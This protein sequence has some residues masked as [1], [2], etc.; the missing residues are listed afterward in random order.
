MRGRSKRLRWMGRGGR[1]GR[2][3]RLMALMSAVSVSL[4]PAMLTAQEG[5]PAAG[6]PVPTLEGERVP[7]GQTI[8]HGLAFL[9]AEAAV[10]RVREIEPPGPG[11]A[12]AE[13]GDFAFTLQIDGVTVIRN[14]VTLKR[15]RLEPGE[16]FFLSAE[17]PYTRWADA[18][19]PSISWIIDLA[20]PDT[21]GDAIFVSEPVEDWPGGARDIELLRNYVQ[22]G[23]V[24]AL[25]GHSG[26]ALVVVTGGTV[27][28]AG[29]GVEQQTL[30]T[31][32]GLLAP[33][34]LQLRAA[35]DGTA[36]YI[37][38]LI[39]Q[40]V[41]EQSAAAEREAAEGDEEPAADEEPAEPEATPTPD[42]GPEGDP[43]GDGLT[44]QQE[45]GAG[46]DPQN[47][48]SDDDG[49]R[50][51]REIELGTDPL[52]PDTDGDGASDGDE[53]LVFGTDPLDPNDTP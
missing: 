47:A 41:L 6:T 30:E 5:T 13:A 46:T 3:W 17:D 29:E 8:A 25:P 44:N 10:W 14:D 9:P 31:G 51:G 11:A 28:V 37:A 43:D 27:E 16:A 36:T 4:L 35:G 50:D 22:P 15:A 23:Q 1:A 18:E 2:S 20:A 52:N 45:E 26:A 33:G 34:E 42:T 53:A 24:A 49:M 19:L 32:G 12:E 7:A 48:D 38:V 21:E 39:G 40:S